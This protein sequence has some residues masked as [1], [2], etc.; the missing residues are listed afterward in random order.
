M[1]RDGCDDALLLIGT[2]Y[3]I[4]D[5]LTSI[6]TYATPTAT[7]A[8]RSSINGGCMWDK[9]CYNVILQCE[10]MM[11]HDGGWMIM[12]ILASHHPGHI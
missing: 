1:I 3:E 11:M 4:E 9:G 8:A 7:A 2:P 6:I 10:W 12:K 5:I